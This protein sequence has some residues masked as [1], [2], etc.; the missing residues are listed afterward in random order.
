MTALITIAISQMANAAMDAI[1]HAK[2]ADRLLEL[3]HVLKAI[4]RWSLFAYIGYVSH[5][6][7]LEWSG[8]IVIMLLWEPLYL[9]L[10]HVRFYRLENWLHELLRRNT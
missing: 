3:W 9:L 5:F 8:L 7:W 6:D 4:S 1:D 2:G 10:R